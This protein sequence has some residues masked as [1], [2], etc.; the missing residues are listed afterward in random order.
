MIIKCIESYD[1]SV[2]DSGPS[3][4]VL[5]PTLLNA[6]NIV[7]NISRDRPS[8]QILININ[9]MIFPIK[10]NILNRAN[11]DSSSSTETF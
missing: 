2:D 4:G 11:N 10:L 1:R 6:Y 7:P 3:K 8:P 9:F 5:K